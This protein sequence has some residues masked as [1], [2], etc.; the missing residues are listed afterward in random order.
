M[1]NRQSEKERQ[2]NK[3]TTNKTQ[4]KY[5][6]RRHP[7][8]DFPREPSKSKSDWLQIYLS[9]I[10]SLLRIHIYVRF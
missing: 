2:R 1:T 8:C 3:T 6:L 4:M 10:F 9:A 7:D 5:Q